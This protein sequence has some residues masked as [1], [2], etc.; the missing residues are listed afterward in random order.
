MGTVAIPVVSTVEAVRLVAIF[1]SFE[2]PTF[3]FV[4]T[5]RALVP[6]FIHSCKFSVAKKLS[7]PP[8]S[9]PHIAEHVFVRTLTVQHPVQKGALP[10]FA[11]GILIF[12][13]AGVKGEVLDFE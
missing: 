5:I 4:I 3:H 13:L 1:I 10:G 7:V 8:G 9:G 6:S 2:T 12:P 11:H